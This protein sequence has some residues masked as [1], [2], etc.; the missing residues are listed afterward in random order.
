MI[1]PLNPNKGTG[2]DNITLKSN[3]TAVNIINSHLANIIVKVW[4]KQIVSRC[5]S[6]LIQTHLQRRP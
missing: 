4:L 3:K 5:K 2:P 6:Y 1:K